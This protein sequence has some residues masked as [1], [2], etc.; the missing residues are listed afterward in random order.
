M[1]DR[2]QLKKKNLTQSQALKKGKLHMPETKE[3]WNQDASLKP[4]ILALRNISRS[5]KGV[6]KTSLTYQ[7]NGLPPGAIGD[8]CAYMCMCTH[9]C[10]YGCCVCVCVCALFTIRIR[11]PE[12]PLCAIPKLDAGYL[13]T[14]GPLFP[15]S[16]QVLVCPPAGMYSLPS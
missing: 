12:C 8:V 10:V 11:S 7:G 5:M 15:P 6:W 4:S 9:A 13:E 16:M 1:Q 14:R 2:V 3:A